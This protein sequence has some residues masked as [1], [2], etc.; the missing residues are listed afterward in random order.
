MLACISPSEINL[1]ETVNTLNYASFA[2]TIKIKPSQ[3]LEVNDSDSKALIESLMK[4]IEQ[5]KNEIKSLKEKEMKDAN[6]EELNKML[7][8]K[9]G[10]VI[11]EQQTLSDEDVEEEKEKIDIKLYEEVKCENNILKNIIKAL[12]ERETNLLEKLNNQPS[13]NIVLTSMVKETNVNKLGEE[14][15]EEENTEDIEKLKNE[16]YNHEKNVVVDEKVLKDL[17]EE[18]DNSDLKITESSFVVNQKDDEIKKL[19]SILRE[20][21]KKKQDKNRLE[22]NV[23]QI[24]EKIK[25][26][27]DF[28]NTLKEKLCENESYKNRLLKQ[29]ND[30]IELI[31]IDL[32]DKNK[33]IR[34]LEQENLRNS[35]L[36]DIKNT[37]ISNLKNKLRTKSVENSENNTRNNNRGYEVLQTMESVN[38]LSAVKKKNIPPIIT[39]EEPADES[40]N[41]IKFVKRTSMADVDQAYILSIKSLVKQIEEEV[42]KKHKLEKRLKIV[43]KEKTNFSN[44]IVKMEEKYQIKISEN[45]Q[46]KEQYEQQLKILELEEGNESSK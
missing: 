45:I 25:K 21:M 30:E 27:K 14:E 7:D 20:E 39:K 41:N 40:S 1:E 29:K 26:L 19:K 10:E 8:K 28:Q 17:D 24:R 6:I 4:E 31:K 38:N 11:N 42:V 2:R 3:N 35:Q 18:N 12:R 46:Q 15:N 22:S 16:Y 33:S 23:T 44:L 34:N 13:D 5:L 9:I 43:F 37:A 32:I 36:L